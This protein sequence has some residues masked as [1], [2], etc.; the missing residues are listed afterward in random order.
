MQIEQR[1]QLTIGFIK[2]GN[3]STETELITYLVSQGDTLEDAQAAIPLYLGM[4]VQF[5]YIDTPTYEAMRDWGNSRT[6]EQITV[7]T[8]AMLQA[9]EG[10]KKKEKE[11]SDL[12]AEKTRL[13]E[14][15]V[16][17]E[18][19]LSEE[20]ITKLI[21]QEEDSRQTLAAEYQSEIAR[22]NEKLASYGG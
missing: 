15:V 16:L 21:Q 4:M 9:Y 3:T 14:D 19:P 5:G 18:S 22:I 17:L 2:Q 11:V 1:L 8:T 6:V 12:L 13:E 10:L 7:A 20:D